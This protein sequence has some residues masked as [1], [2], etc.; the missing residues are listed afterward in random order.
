MRLCLSRER[1]S[2]TGC[3]NSIPA[4]LLRLQ[5]IL[6]D[7]NYLPTPLNVNNKQIQIRSPFFAVCFVACKWLTNQP[8]S[9]SNPFYLRQ[10]VPPE[11]IN[12]TLL[13]DDRSCLRKRSCHF[14]RRKRCQQR[15]LCVAGWQMVGRF[16]NCGECATQ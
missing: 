8:S 10:F 4:I 5:N 6:L 11:R 16:A 13:Y 15:R 2:S 14:T 12:Q 7:Y 3:L 1:K 9:N